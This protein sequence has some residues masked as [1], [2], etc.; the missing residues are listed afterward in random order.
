MLFSSHPGDCDCDASAHTHSGS[1]RPGVQPDPDHEEYVATS[2]RL[3]EAVL[4]GNDTAVCETL[5]SKYCDVNFKGTFSLRVKFTDSV[6]HEEAADEVT[7]GYE[8]FKQDI[9]SLFA[10]AHTGHLQIT[11]KLLVSNSC[12]FQ[13]TSCKSS[14]RVLVFLD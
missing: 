4:E 12:E 9:T 8:E 10:A 14:N 5:E 11:K 1:M 7:T 13:P 3:I 6:Q 2:R